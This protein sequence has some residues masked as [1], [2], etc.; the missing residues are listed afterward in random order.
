[1]QW[2]CAYHSK[3]NSNTNYL[4]DNEYVKKDNVSTQRTC[5]QH[6]ISS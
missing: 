3:E 1:M 6:N 4:I 2:E 5:V